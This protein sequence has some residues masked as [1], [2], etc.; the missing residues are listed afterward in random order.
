[1][2]WEIEPANNFMATDILVSFIYPGLF[3]KFSHEATKTLRK[4]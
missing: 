1:M 4:R 2:R 3:T